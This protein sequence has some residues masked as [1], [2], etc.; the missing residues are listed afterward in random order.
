MR[1]G[2]E[3]AGKEILVWQSNDADRPLVLDGETALDEFAASFY[4]R[5][6]R[7]PMTVEERVHLLIES[8]YGT[9]VAPD[10]RDAA[11][12]PPMGGQTTTRSCGPH[13]TESDRLQATAD[14]GRRRH[15]GIPTPRHGQGCRARV[16]PRLHESSG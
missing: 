6:K 11:S 7:T 16:A 14:G 15:T 9:F 5:P 12:T 3:T 1:V 10:S 2:G 8:R 13:R 4:A